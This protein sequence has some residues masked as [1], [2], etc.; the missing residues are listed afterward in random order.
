MIYFEIETLFINQSEFIKRILRS[1][2]KNV[3]TM[4]KNDVDIRI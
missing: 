2:E 1:F 3:Y 4:E